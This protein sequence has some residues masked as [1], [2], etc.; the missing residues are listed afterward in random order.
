MGDWELLQEYAEHRSE[1]A[2]AELVQ[3]HLNWVHSAA[4]RQVGDPHLA[5][6]VTQAVFVLLARKAGS[7]RSGTILT[8]W[9][10]RTTR[11]VAA[12]AMRNEYRRKRR[13]EVA[14]T[15]NAITANSPDDIWNQLAPH[16]DQA[17]AALSKTDR[18]AILSRFYEKKSLREVGEQLGLSE[19]AAKKRV[20]R[21]VEKMR[22]FLTRRGVVL[23][24]TVLVGVLVEQTV[25]AAPAALGVTVVKTATAGVS[26]SAVL[27]QLARE[28]LSAWRWAKVNLVAGISA[29]TVAAAILGVNTVSRPRPEVAP[30]MSAE[31]GVAV[32]AR[33]ITP[34]PPA[35]GSSVT[36]TNEAP[37]K[38]I[39]NIHVV[40]QR[41]K[42]PL[43]GVQIVVER[44][45]QKSIG[46]TD[47]D[48]R[49]HTE[50]PEKDPSRLTIS[51]HKD[52]FVPL[53]V[54]WDAQ[55]RGF[56]IP[57]EF[58]FALEPA[59]SIG[60]VVQDEQGR[61][62]AGATVNVYL[63]DDSYGKNGQI[64]V[65]QWLFKTAITDGFGRWRFDQAPADLSVLGIRL[66]HPDYVMT[67]YPGYPDN[68][69][70]PDEKLRDMTAELV[71]KKGF[72]VSGGVFDIQ[73][74]PIAGA[75]VGL[76]QGRY[77]SD[78]LK[79]TTDPEGAFR[80]NNAKSG[81]T[82]LFVQARG[83]APDLKSIEPG[84][85][86]GPFNFR[87]EPGHFI[88][89][90]VIDAQGNPLPG[91]D[92][93]VDTW[94][95]LQLLSWHTTTGTN[96]VFEWVDAP[97]D[98]VQCDFL[99]E[100]YRSVSDLDLSPNSTNDVVTLRPP[101]FARGSVTDAETGQPIA[102]FTVTPGRFFAE[103][104]EPYWEENEQRSFSGGQ[105]Q[106][107][108]AFSGG[109]LYFLRADVEGY[110]GEI[111]PPFD[112]DGES[113]VHNFKLTRAAW[114]QGVVRTPDGQPATN[115]DVLLAMPGPPLMVD[116]DQSS[117]G[118]PL[119]PVGGSDPR[120]TRTDAEGR[121]KFAPIDKPFLVTAL[122]DTG[123]AQ[124]AC[125]HPGALPDLRLEPWARIEGDMY[126]GSRPAVRQ[127]VH[128]WGDWSPQ[129]NRPSVMFQ[130]NAMT[131][132]TGHFVMDRVP[133]A[134][135]SVGRWIRINGGRSGSFTTTHNVRLRTEH[136][137]TSHVTI[138]G[139]GQPVTGQLLAPA[140]LDHKIDWSES[141][142]SLHTKTPLPPKT[143][144]DWNT[145]TDEQKRARQQIVAAE[146]K[147]YEE[148]LKTMVRYPLAVL[149][150]G[151]FRVEDVPPGDY[152]LD[153]TV[154]EPRTNGVAVTEQPVVSLVHEFTIPDLPG[155]HTDE[156]LDLGD[157]ELKPVKLRE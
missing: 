109:Y 82:F 56:Q 11:F 113:F 76:G 107:N 26:A 120:S 9:L 104:E 57:E 87:L 5:E 6:D 3:R 27:P 103:G 35:A 146:N 85:D 92:V 125:E 74:R 119:R 127:R 53:R 68:A 49:F 32:W 31:T 91:V 45:G 43:A 61:P 16:L 93:S 143:P 40:E 157:L 18:A 7:L 41:T 86:S 96:G 72:T 83:F 37:S 134:N 149:P 79:T 15:M 114:I 138:G 94:R 58:T 102:S 135:V 142:G 59:G 101:F 152:Q 154:S 20:S 126:I 98:N 24:G 30:P 62:I 147:A 12:R 66:R 156:P 25:Q 145:M 44:D 155:G 21:A 115:A 121:F 33:V 8:G 131:D 17:V 42:Q 117:D 13:E 19:E 4:R 54:M 123:Y 89:G 99:K 14:S 34:S 48:G 36:A 105:Y 70:L 60:G 132:N 112:P 65:D 75:F 150:D 64:F 128:L 129:S 88:H 124:A 95:S 151:S 110:A 118:K 137:Q 106:W 140:G 38:R 111:S 52:D 67:W 47:K 136:G 80:F 55:F 23:G 50:L 2:F 22:E 69:R 139:T 153:V 78:F 148:A 1:A 130:A 108:V 122:H 97:A 116:V 133:A 71:M 46:S 81:N 28:T 100:G 141:S 77:Y 84:N 63:N 90:L 29:A 144:D 51:A 39:I 73:G 10:F